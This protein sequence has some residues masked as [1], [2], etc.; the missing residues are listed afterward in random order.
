MV[1][2]KVWVVGVMLRHGSDLW[3]KAASEARAHVVREILE[4]QSTI[5]CR[6]GSDPSLVKETCILINYSVRRRGDSSRPI[7]KTG[8]G[9]SGGRQG[10]V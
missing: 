3:R 5:I 9:G 8:E 6:G 2:L 4:Q 7:A 1:M 10:L